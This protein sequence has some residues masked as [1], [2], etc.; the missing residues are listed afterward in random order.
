M[1]TV[2]D[3][4]EAAHKRAE[5][6]WACGSTAPPITYR[7]RL[8]WLRRATVTRCAGCGARRFDSEAVK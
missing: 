8:T 5:R 4:F 1:S 6:C 2:A 3:F 7:D